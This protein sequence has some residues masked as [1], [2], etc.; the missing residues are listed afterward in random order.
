MRLV[1]VAAAL[2]L[3]ACASAQLA[4]DFGDLRFS[5]RDA[6]REAFAALEAEAEAPAPA[7]ADRCA[8]EAIARSARAPWVQLASR[9]PDLES[10]RSDAAAIRARLQAVEALE[11]ALR[12]GAEPDPHYLPDRNAGALIRY[13][14]ALQAAGEPRLRQLF[15]RAISDQTP[16]VMT[17]G[18]LAEPFLTGLSPQARMLWPRLVTA[19]LAEIDCDNTAW[20]RAQLDEIGWF[21]ISRY[22]AEADHAAWLLVQ[23]ADR[24][25]AFQS[26]IL[27]RLQQRADAGETDPR[28]VAYLWDRV[29]VK[30]GRP[31]RYGTQMD[32]VDGAV[33]PINGLDA[34]SAEIERRRAAIDMQSYASYRAMMAQL[35]GCGAGD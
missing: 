35:V 28:N 33:E 29:A 25:P 11:A 18:E 17:A 13:G 2:V 19:R 9:A 27:A 22:G 26:D 14:D 4:T 10:W 7:N 12:T 5:Q 15:E 1:L 34:D 31:Q 24:T 6:D 21:D 32:C 16:R 20:L 8:P 3:S 23:H 30:D